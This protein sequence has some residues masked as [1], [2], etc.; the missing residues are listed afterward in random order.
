MSDMTY[1]A[2]GITSR[3]TL[4][5]L[6]GQIRTPPFSAKARME[7]GYCLRRLQRGDVLSMPVSRPMPSVGVRC[8]ELR[9]KDANH[10]WRVINRV[11]VDR[12]LVIE[13]LVV[14]QFEL[15]RARSLELRRARSLELRRARSLELRR[16]RSLNL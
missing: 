15:R 6:R 9:I 2:N 3:Q 11:E 1:P 7:V 12:V 13:V 10:T 5:W 4:I 8:H 16:A 14:R